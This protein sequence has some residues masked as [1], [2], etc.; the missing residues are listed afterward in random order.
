MDA[1]ILIVA[2]LALIFVGQAGA[3]P[4][5]VIV[6]GGLKPEHEGVYRAVLDRIGP[7]GRL[8]V[9]PT[10]SG[11]PE[12]SGPLTV[13]DFEQYA[14][15]GQR[16]VLIDIRRDTPERAHAPS[17]VDAIASCDA[18]WFTGGV[19]SRIVN[20]FR[21][22]GEDSPAYKAVVGV[23]ERGGVVGGTSAG[24]AMMTDP[25]IFW[26]NSHEALLLGEV[27]DVGDFGVAF[28]RGMGLLPDAVV[29]Q[30]FFRRG[31]LG[32]LLVACQMTGRSKGFGIGENCAMVVDLDAM[33]G[34]VIGDPGVLAI[35]LVGR[36]AVAAEDSAIAAFEA[37]YWPNG[38]SFSLADEASEA[39]IDDAASL[40]LVEEALS[41]SP[42][43]YDGPLVVDVV[44]APLPDDYVGFGTDQAFVLRPSEAYALARQAA[45]LSV[46][47]ARLD[48]A[49]KADRSGPLVDR[50]PDRW[51]VSQETLDD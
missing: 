45:R 22:N 24:A 33:T 35:E 50:L 41:G 34:R 42:R 36:H 46:A 27:D 43:S 26:G 17:Y 49:G 1:R 48:R 10:A 21:P 37:R 6:G 47:K 32:R 13:K 9:L 31:R 11:V 23:L 18:V 29:D 38:A 16:V 7:D 5:L 14:S 40:R 20:V 2:A 8:G 44:R 12:R 30:H 3:G 15:P 4:T 51:V 19:Q 39:P 28:G 25:M